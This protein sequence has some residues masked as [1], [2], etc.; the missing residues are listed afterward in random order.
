[1]ESELICHLGLPA[2][3]SVKISEIE[4]F[5]FSTIANAEPFCDDICS[6][7]MALRVFHIES[8]RDSTC[9]YCN[10][11]KAMVVLLAFEL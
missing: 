4:S 7:Y 1:M 6:L 9:W 5:L 10:A 3:S 2:I 11:L 8:I